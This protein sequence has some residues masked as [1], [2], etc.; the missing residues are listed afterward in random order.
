MEKL[1]IGKPKV[2]A[3][4]T[5]YATAV[6]IDGQWLQFATRH[7]RKIETPRSSKVVETWLRSGKLSK[8]ATRMVVAEF[9]KKV[10][11]LIK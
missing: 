9:E 8:E 1:Q 4:E 7:H 3:T 11:E 6:R 10:E 2:A 5:I